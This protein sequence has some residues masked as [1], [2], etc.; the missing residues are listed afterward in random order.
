[1]IEEIL[2]P[3]HL[4]VIL[5]VALSLFGPKK[6]PELGKGLA[7]GIRG[8]KNASSRA[9]TNLRSVYASPTVIILGP[10]E[11]YSAGFK[12]APPSPRNA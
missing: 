3:R 10:S 5:A 2:Q 12:Y 1:M 9:R 11:E 4:F 6:L 7:E 8:F